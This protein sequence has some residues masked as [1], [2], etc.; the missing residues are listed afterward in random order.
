M[1]SFDPKRLLMELVM[2]RIAT[3]L[4]SHHSAQQ[5]LLNTQEMV[6]Q[7][8]NHIDNKTTDLGAETWS[9]PV[10]NYRS[11]ERLDAEL[12]L[13]KSSFVVFCPSP[14]LSNTGDYVARSAAGVPLIAVRAEDGTAKV[15]RNACRH[16][17]VQLAQGH[18]CK[19]VLVC[20]YHGWAY[21]LDG[22]LKNIT[23]GSGF[24]EVDTKTSGLVPVPSKEINGLVYV[25]QE[26]SDTTASSLDL[27]PQIIPDNYELVEIDEMDVDANW[28]L[29]IESALEG[30]HIR[31]THTKTFFPVQYDNL[32]VVEAF[33]GN[34]RVTFPYQTIESLR[35]KPQKGWSTNGRM[36]QLYHLFPNV[37]VSTFPNCLQV[38]VLEPLG[39]EKT[40]QHTYLLGRVATGTAEER[41][42]MTESILQGQAFAK[43]GAIEDREVVMSAQQGLHSGANE[44]LTFGLFES[45]IGRL[46]AGLSR[47]LG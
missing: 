32:T 29:F 11:Q 22:Q 23:H 43:T 17:G 19:R 6:L 46:H 34:S 18:G 28:K 8:F 5:P 20:P 45:A 26:A 42:T 35:N 37:I 33:G 16:R 13:I 2:S 21:A 7:I 9:E 31:A 14:A 27:I 12:G 40:R 24:P 4:A 41:K 3:P 38:V 39:L 10:S 1:A 47:E 25:G 30:Y 36:T 15:F 44:H